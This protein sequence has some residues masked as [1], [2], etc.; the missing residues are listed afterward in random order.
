MSAYTEPE[1]HAVPQENSE[2]PGNPQGCQG[3]QPSDGMRA[4]KAGQRG[5]CSHRI[6][7]GQQRRIHK[8]H[9]ALHVHLPQA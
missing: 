4:A 3:S 5:A 7:T 9:P 2:G 1:I 6:A 8:T